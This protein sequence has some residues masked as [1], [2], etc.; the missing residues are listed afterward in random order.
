MPS[1]YSPGEARFPGP[2][3]HGFA[4]TKER[5]TDDVASGR[6]RTVQER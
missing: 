1:I 6:G 5:F 4:G 2:G 3:E